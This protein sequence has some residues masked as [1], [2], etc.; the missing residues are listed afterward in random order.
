VPEGEDEGLVIMHTDGKCNI[1][2]DPEGAIHL[3]NCTATKVTVLE[4]QNLLAIA[5]SLSEE[6]PVD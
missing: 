1:G 3:I 2:I 6:E 5:Q 4:L